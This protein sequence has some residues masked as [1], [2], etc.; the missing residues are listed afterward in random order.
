MSNLLPPGGGEFHSKACAKM[1]R[2]TYLSDICLF[3]SLSLFE[4][5][6]QPWWDLQTCSKF[7]NDFLKRFT[8]EHLDLDFRFSEC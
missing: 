4:T 1:D 7:K 2:F 6:P 5:F 8:L 3:Q